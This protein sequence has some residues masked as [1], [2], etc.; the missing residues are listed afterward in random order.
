[1]RTP[2]VG[3]VP[4]RRVRPVVAGSDFP[5]DPLDFL[6]KVHVAHR[7]RVLS[8]LGFEAADQ[9]LA[10]EAIHQPPEK[11]YRVR[12]ASRRR[13]TLTCHLSGAFFDEE[14]VGLKVG[15]RLEVVTR[16]ARGGATL[17]L[18]AEVV[19]VN[20]NSSPVFQLHLLAEG[21]LFLSA[22]RGDEICL[23]VRGNTTTA[24][25]KDR[26]Q[27]ARGDLDPDGY[28]S[29]SIYP[30]ADWLSGGLTPSQTSRRL[31]YVDRF[32]ESQNR[33]FGLAMDP[34]ANPVLLVHGGPGTG[35]TTV[36]SEIIA[37]H[38]QRGRRVLVL[39]H[40][41]RGVD[42]LGKRVHDMGVSIHRAGNDPTVVDPTL[43]PFRIRQGCEFPSEAFQSASR[44]R[45]ADWGELSRSRADVLRE[46]HE[47]LAAKT[48]ELSGAVRD[49]GV[50]FSTFGTL[51]HDEVVRN[52]G[53]FD[54][55]II[56]EATRLGMPELVDGLSFAEQQAILVGDP[57]QLGNIP[58]DPA[59]RSAL[60]VQQFRFLRRFLEGTGENPHRYPLEAAAFQLRDLPPPA[61]L[62]RLRVQEGV[63]EATSNFGQRYAA[64][65]RLAEVAVA[66]HEEGPFSA[67]VRTSSRPERE[68]P[69]VFLDQNRRSLPAIV[70]VLSELIYEGRLQPGRE[71]REG[72][73]QGVVQ[74]IDTRNIEAREATHG[75]SKKNPT[76]ARVVARL[77][78]D[79]VLN[80][81]R[82][83]RL[84]PEDLAVIATYAEQAECIQAQLRRLLHNNSP[85]LAQLLPRIASVDAFQ[86]SQAKVVIV[87]LTRSNEK[88][89]VGFLAEERR[90]G[91]ALGRAADELYV[92]GDTGTLVEDNRN[93]DSKAFFGRMH[94]LIGTFGSV[95]PLRKEK[96]PRR[97]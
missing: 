57:L 71:A 35:K 60:T 1:M 46:H 64:W 4:E 41:N 32:D 12:E 58:L 74:W 88:G 81:D 42:V 65:A 83:A 66:V 2:L 76:E 85:L 24:K 13:D 78:L 15:T 25:Y 62:D 10:L 30:R 92:V 29:S 6:A 59:D 49:G 17:V 8:Y 3:E 11:E 56:D 93:P 73:S 14:L 69:Y 5:G 53:R 90:I 89:D 40:S 94:T 52:M 38:V 26:L 22:S 47:R 67:M 80:R 79:R 7:L 95:T 18:P 31:D 54:V 68:L 70:C 50:V 36:L 34:Q 27:Q 87:S 63:E 72:E 21:P 28:T 51:I 23:M 84:K 77:V 86:G 43:H 48:R 20:G 61:W 44:R 45:S 37:G 55:V 19:G 16:A 33:A 91:V 96:Q 9:A 39:S 97:R 75:T 82:A